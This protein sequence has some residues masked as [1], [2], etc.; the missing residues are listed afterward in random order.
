MTGQE[1]DA[2]GWKLF[3]WAVFALLVSVA[4]FVKWTAIFFMAVVITALTVK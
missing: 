3:E 1:G 4:F 2:V